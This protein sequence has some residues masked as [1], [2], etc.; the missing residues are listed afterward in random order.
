MFAL[1]DK[2][3]DPS[4]LCDMPTQEHRD[5]FDSRRTPLTFWERS[6]RPSKAS[7]RLVGCLMVAGILAIAWFATKP[8]MFQKTVR[9]PNVTH[10]GPVTAPEIPPRQVDPVMA[11]QPARQTQ[12]ITKCLG[13]Q[14]TSGYTDGVCPAGSRSVNAELP[15]ISVADGMTQDQRL[16]SQ[17]VNRIEAQRVLAHE[18]QVS[19]YVERTSNECGMLNAAVA[20]YD[21]EARQPLPTW[22]HDRL[23]E[24][25]KAA[26][27]RQFSLRC[28]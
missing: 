7:G 16:A 21:A 4:H 20:A 23:R 8:P 25:R 19:Q 18:I 14:G 2:L 26:R 9:Q 3:T 15:A 13:P 10:V 11:A 22:R 6:L 24:M 27:D 1:N 17:Q 12:L 28:Q 5:P